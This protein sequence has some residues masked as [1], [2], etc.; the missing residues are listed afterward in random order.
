MPAV[1]D[2]WFEPFI[3]KQLADKKFAD[4]LHNKII[5]DKLFYAI[6]QKVTLQEQLVSLDEFIKLPSSHHH[7]H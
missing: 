7:H 4:E 5:T 3:Q 2:D 6:E 1:N